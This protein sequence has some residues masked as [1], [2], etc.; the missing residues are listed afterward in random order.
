MSI[1]FKFCTK[2]LFCKE[3]NHEK[4]KMPVYVFLL[5]MVFSA[6]PV[7]AAETISVP[8]K[9]TCILY[10]SKDKEFPTGNGKKNTTYLAD[11]ATAK[12]SN[13]KSSR[14][15]VATFRKSVHDNRDP[16]LCNSQ[17]SR[18]YQFICKNQ[19]KDI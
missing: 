15:S 14:P 10:S 11:V 16:T 19:F 7:Q 12:V 1:I 3:T 8:S 6:V 5:S 4:R 2:Q 18:N 9:W 17:K 13:L